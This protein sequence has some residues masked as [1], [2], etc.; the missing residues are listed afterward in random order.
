M[1][2][3]KEN[4]NKNIFRG[5]DIRGVYPTELDED[6]AYTFGKGYATHC[7]YR[8]SCYLCHATNVTK[9]DSMSYD[10]YPMQF[11][12]NARDDHSDE[13]W[14]RARFIRPEDLHYY[15]DIG[16]NYF[17]TDN[18]YISYFVHV[19]NNLINMIFLMW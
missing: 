15:N 3:I 16:I 12:M 1:Y 6:T 11:C 4:I 18:I 19:L 13:A 10:N 5:Y 2:K 14:I 9:E 7:P 17:K 8:D